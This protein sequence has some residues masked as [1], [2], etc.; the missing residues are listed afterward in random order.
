[1]HKLTNTDKD[2]VVL[3]DKSKNVYT[4]EPGQSAHV[5]ICQKDNMFEYIELMPHGNSACLN[6]SMKF[7]ISGEVK[8]DI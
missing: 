6:Q 3:Q 7:I 2:F 1:M 8:K 5:V 4:L